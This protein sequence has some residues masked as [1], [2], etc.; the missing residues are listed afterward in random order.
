MNKNIFSIFPVET[1]SRN[2]SWPNLKHR[3]RTL[4]RL[5]VIIALSI[6]FIMPVWWMVSTSLKPLVQVWEYPPH[7]IPQTIHLSNYVEVLQTFPFLISL[8]NTLI[9][10]FW[11]MIGRLLVCS[12]VAYAF[13]RLRFP[14]RNLLF[15]LVLSTMMIPGWVTLIPKYL[16][17]RDLKWLNTFLPLTFPPLLASDAFVIFLLRQFY[18]TIS[19]EITDAARLDGCSLLGVW[20]RIMLPL[21]KPALGTIAILT[22]LGTWNDFFEPLI[23]LNTPDVQTL[24]LAVANW[25]IAFANDVLQPQHLKM[26]LATLITLP[27]VVVFYF[28]QR[29]LIK[30]FNFTGING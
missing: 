28:A 27:P 15:I 10:M 23:Y 5:T 8:R 21:A 24:T 30:G 19:V 9:I 25:R 4:P 1:L 14:G 11:N 7:L 17:F 16:L 2:L 13:A 22:F 29:T 18:R 20:W 3:F 12:L 26:A 6:V